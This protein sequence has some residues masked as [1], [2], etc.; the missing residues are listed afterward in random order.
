MVGEA[1]E[2]GVWRGGENLAE[3][4][5]E[6]IEYFPAPPEGFGGADPKD[7]SAVLSETVRAWLHDAASDGT[8]RPGV[9]YVWYDEQAVQLRMSFVSGNR[10]SIPFGVKPVFVEDV[11]DVLADFFSGAPREPGEELKVFAREVAGT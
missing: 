10:D 2:V 1:A 4:A 11:Q 5:L 6:N 9:V 3:E 7:L 8:G